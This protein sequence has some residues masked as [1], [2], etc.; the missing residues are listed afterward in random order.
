MVQ[1]GLPDLLRWLQ[2]GRSK[3]VIHMGSGFQLPDFPAQGVL[4]RTWWKLGD[5]GFQACF[6]GCDLIVERMGNGSAAHDENLLPTG[7]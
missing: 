3:P 6:L 1:S 4:F 2:A 7:S 5:F